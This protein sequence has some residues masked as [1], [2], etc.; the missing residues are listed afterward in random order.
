[1]DMI[2]RTLRWIADVMTILG[3]SGLGS[4]GLFKK[5]RSML[6]R[7][8]FNFTLILIKMLFILIGAIIIYFIFVYVYKFIVSFL[9]GNSLNIYWEEGKEFTHIISYLLSFLITMPIFLLWS[10]VISSFSLY[11]AKLLWNKMLSS[12]YSFDLTKYNQLYKLEIIEAFYGT[13]DAIRIDVKNVL[14]SFISK[15]KLN[16]VASNE[17][18]GDPQFGVIKELKVRYSIDGTEKD[19]IVKEGETLR[20]P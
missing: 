14:Q 20:I 3:I 16:V 5:D 11:Y 19:A 1:M 7:K 12:V 2:E 18:A 13:S 8:V 9:I 15:G 17:L 10:L 4:Y 6:G